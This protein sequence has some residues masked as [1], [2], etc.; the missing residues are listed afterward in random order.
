M[1][2]VFKIYEIGICED[3]EIELPDGR[4]GIVK[5]AIK[6]PICKKRATSL[7]PTEIR[8]AIREEGYPLR[9]GQEVYCDEIESIKK[10]MDDD[11][12]FDHAETIEE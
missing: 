8:K 9:K 11:Y 5:G 6:T 3:E 10:Y 4:T 7:T 2:K 1:Y 12:Y